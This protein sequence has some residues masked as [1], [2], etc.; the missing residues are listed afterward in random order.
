MI[1]GTPVTPLVTITQR[2][3]YDQSMWMNPFVFLSSMLDHST[4]SIPSTCNF[5]SYGM[6]DVNSHFSSFVSSSYVNPTFGSRG[7]MPPYSPF[8]FGGGY[9]PQPNPMVGFYTHPS[10][11]P[12]PKFTFPGESAQ[13][14]GPSTYYIQSIYASSIVLVPKNTFLTESLPL[15]SGVL[16]RWSQL[17]RMRNP[18]S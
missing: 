12:N 8:S 4:Q 15:S 3:V 11:G 7:T 2:M 9:I 10:Y 13:M 1:G 17:Y 14:G 5:F 16:S 18:P 6:P